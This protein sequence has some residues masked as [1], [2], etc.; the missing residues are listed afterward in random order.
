MDDSSK[1]NRIFINDHLNNVIDKEHSRQL[2]GLDGLMIM[3]CTM[4]SES[5]GVPV[6]IVSCLPEQDY[7][8]LA[9]NRKIACPCCN[10]MSRVVRHDYRIREV[11]DIPTVRQRMVLKIYYCMYK[12]TSTNNCKTFHVDMPFVEPSA[13]MTSR[14]DSVL[15]KETFTDIS[16][17]ALASLYGVS[18]S[19][20]RALFN[21]EVERRCKNV[22]MVAHKHMGIDETKIHT[23]DSTEDLSIVIMGKDSMYAEEK[24]K[25]CALERTRRN[26][27]TVIEILEKFINPND[28]ETFT[29]DMCPAYLNAVH[30]V[31]P[32]ARVIIDR[33][34]V[35]MNLIIRT[36]QTATRIYEDL[37]QQLSESYNISLPNDVVDEKTLL[38]E[39]AYEVEDEA[40]WDGKGLPFASTDLVQVLSN[41]NGGVAAAGK[42][43]SL[44][45]NYRNIWFAVN[46]GHHTQFAKSH[47]GSLM[48]D[49]PVFEELYKFKEA[50]REDFYECLTKDE[51][52][53]YAEQM[54]AR[55][56]KMVDSYPSKSKKT[57]KYIFEPLLVFF[58]TLTGSVFTE[59]IFE[60]FNDPIGKR[61][62]NA[63]LE[64]CN[65]RIKLLNRVG[66]GLTFKALQAKVVY[67]NL[68]TF[69]HAVPSASAAASAVYSYLINRYNVPN[70][71][72]PSGETIK[73]AVNAAAK[74]ELVARIPFASAVTPLD[75]QMILVNDPMAFEYLM[76]PLAKIRN[77]TGIVIP[78]DEAD[79]YD[80]VSEEVF[81]SP[82]LEDLIDNPTRTLQLFLSAISFLE[83]PA[84]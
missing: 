16:S 2:L 76:N 47:F 3:D 24:S 59:A 10:R 12:C 60:Y 71:T 81:D 84:K 67:G 44:V 25:V 29:M 37:K 65:S 62:S 5:D 28:V 57:R 53:E 33:F 77:M 41:P 78:D 70:M 15:R 18:D 34:H 39:T 75:Y 52:L 13:R 11:L 21:D 4:V 8:Y 82:Y 49:F 54:R 74:I 32:H 43:S 22:Q 23:I 1:S 50:M 55:L 46:W 56:Q 64:G 42:I 14:L 58:K 31:L 27:A 80:W 79:C 35:V 20:I 69:T 51:A 36:R 40:K 48:H 66:R 17:T 7:E 63:M 45:N 38:G 72:V 30:T 6:K 73:S 83:K 61:Y 68:T 9:H 26:E 19:T